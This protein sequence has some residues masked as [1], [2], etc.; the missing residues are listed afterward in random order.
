MWP[1]AAPH[2]KNVGQITVAVLNPKFL[3]EIHINP[4]TA[5]PKLAKPTSN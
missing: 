1:P 2:K 3:T 5:N 4:T